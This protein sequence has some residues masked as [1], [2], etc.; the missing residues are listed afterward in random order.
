MNVYICFT[1]GY[2]EVFTHKYVLFR[3]MLDLKKAKQHVLLQLV[4]IRGSA[5]V[6]LAFFLSLD[7]FIT[8]YTSTYVIYYCVVV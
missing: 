7:L 6:M 5:W 3:V 2:D 8:S 1:I 4:E